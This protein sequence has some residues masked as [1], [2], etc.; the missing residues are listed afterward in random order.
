MT[1]PLR[2]STS[3]TTS[4]PHASQNTAPVAEFRCLFT[5][6]LRRKQKRWQDG[7][8]KFHTFNNRVMLYDTSRNF[9][10][11]TYWKETNDLQEGDE[12]TLDKGVMV[13][14]ADALGVSQTDLTPLFEKKK[15]S[16]TTKSVMAS[17]LPR[18]SVPLAN[19]LRGGSQLRHK[20]LNAVLKAPKGPIGKALP[21]KSPFELRQEKEK[22]NE[23]AAA[24]REAKRQKTHHTTRRNITTV[25]KATT[26][27]ST[28]VQ[29]PARTFSVTT[30]PPARTALVHTK[31]KSHEAP[32]TS[33]HSEPN[34]DSSQVTIPSSPSGIED[35]WRHA[36]LATATREIASA[37]EVTA[38]AT[39]A[40]RTPRL[41]QGKIPLP[42]L[43]EPP[44][45]PPPPSSPPVSVSNRFSSDDFAPQ[46]AKAPVKAPLGKPVQESVKEPETEK[47]SQSPPLKRKTKS[48]RLPT[49]TK[50]GILLCQ[51]RSQQDRISQESSRRL[52]KEPISQKQKR[53]AISVEEHII[54]LSDDHGPLMQSRPPKVKSREAMSKQKDKTPQERDDRR[55]AKR[56]KLV[57]QLPEPSND[58][59]G[60]IEFVHGALDQQIYPPL[61]PQCSRFTTSM[62][63]E[64]HET[65]RP[66]SIEKEKSTK[67]PQPQPKMRP[68]GRPAKSA[69]Q[70][71]K[72]VAEIEVDLET[73]IVDASAPK[74]RI[75]EPV[76]AATSQKTSSRQS[77]AVVAPPDPVTDGKS[78]TTAPH[79]TAPSAGG[80]RKK[81]KGA[82]SKEPSPQ[83][84]PTKL[85]EP[86]LPFPKRPPKTKKKAG[87]LMSTTELSALLQRSDKLHLRDD[88]IEEDN[89]QIN[90]KILPSP[91]RA[92]QRSRSENDAPIPSMSESW[93]RKNIPPNNVPDLKD[94]DTATKPK[95][96]PKP[97][98]FKPHPKSK[99][100]TLASL[101]KKT[102]PRH[103]F[104][105][106]RSLNLDTGVGH[107]GTGDD[108]DAYAYTELPSPV[109]DT[110]VGPWSTEADDLFDWRP[111][112]R[113]KLSDE[114]GGML[115]DGDS[116]DDF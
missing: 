83:P 56:S 32:D 46:P 3:S 48:L 36:S 53:P 11:D 63:P 12:L 57:Q 95:P 66:K 77:P 24:E 74:V 13:E 102:D 67:G 91:N 76:D 58:L 1:A 21:I 51:S 80:F 68:P 7:F 45:P 28:T 37:T 18:S 33:L 8:V 40:A 105:R 111:P 31:P 97:N 101:V 114:E 23:W 109:L 35:S 116:E 5:H 9:L 43:K 107:I 64:R 61:S 6:D 59:F 90:T 54:L 110:D 49:G 72:P 112:G 44:K 103:R 19:I 98:P 50:R 15:D 4:T 65:S 94:S 108:D 75:P 71:K 41:P 89:S 2:P 34:H 60:D 70:T 82:A 22:E 78:S 30:Q 73:A 79:K 47:P 88:P 27:S 100:S 84:S 92:L 85:F 25:G 42:Q 20:S 81:G 87:P 93:E 69:L 99:E 86:A 39:P 38:P 104:K 106:T 10:G 29:P 62:S 17:T 14:V 55:R 16:P 96:K 26:G 52:S 115:V 113:E